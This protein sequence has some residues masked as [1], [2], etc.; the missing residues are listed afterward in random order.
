MRIPAR[1][2]KEGPNVAIIVNVCIDGKGPFPFAV[3][4]GASS[5]TIDAA[6]ADRL[7]LP[8]VGTVETF[9]GVGCS[10]TGQERSI[11]SWSLAG[12][13]LHAQAATGAKLPDFGG[14]GQPDGLIGSDVWGAF[15]ALRID[16]RHDDLVVPGAEGPAPNRETIIKKPASSP[17]AP[18]LLTGRPQIVAPM[19]VDAAPAQTLISVGVAF[20]SHPTTDFTP[21][22]GASTS[23]VDATVAKQ[24]GLTPVEVKERQNT[25]CSVVSVPEVASGSWSIARKPLLP[26]SIATTSLLTS[27]PSAG[28]LGSDQMSRYGSVVFD[29][30]GGR[31]VLG[32]G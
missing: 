14:P 22:T 21:D 11:R 25:V 29:Y 30:R 10:A 2:S 7:E 18:A 13:P 26:Q 15:G 17:L 8:R 32:A 5:V 16:F 3:D 27:G 6:F 1:V 31:L 12:I 4:T 20:G 9:S 24:A 28:L 23:V 19:S